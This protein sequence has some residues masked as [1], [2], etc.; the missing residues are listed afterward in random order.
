MKSACRCPDF[1]SDD[2]TLCTILLRNLKLGKNFQLLKS[3]VLP[4]N[5]HIFMTQSTRYFS[6]GKNC[7]GTSHLCLRLVWRIHM[8]AF[9]SWSIRTEWSN[10][11]FICN[12]AGNSMSFKKWKPWKNLL[13]GFFVSFIGLI[14][15][16]YLNIVGYHIYNDRGIFSLIWY[17]LGVIVIEAFVIYITL[18]FAEKLSEK[19][20]LIRYIE[21]FSI[22]FMLLLAYILFKREPK[23]NKWFTSRIYGLCTFSDRRGFK[24]S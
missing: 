2:L 3:M 1:I 16:G 12:N 23:F 8:R 5:R 24:L 13:V 10:T 9:R 14:P 4:V 18:L 19:K 15:L 22:F 11:E 7:C 17:L 20:K 21:L 6:L